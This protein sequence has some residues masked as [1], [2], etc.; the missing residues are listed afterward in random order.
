MNASFIRK[1]W[2]KWLI[3][4]AIGLGVLVLFFLVKSKTAPPK[5]PITERPRAVRVIAVPRV[6]VVP[7]AVGYG[8]VQPGMTWSAVAEVAGKIVKIHPELKK[9]ALIPKG[10]LLFKIDPE[11]Y[12]MS[13]GRSRADLENLIA[14]LKELQQREKDLRRQLN[15]EKR[16]LALA[17]KQLARKRKLYR[18]KVLS[19]SEVEKEAQNVLAQQNK[20]QSYQSSLN[21]IPAQKR[22]LQAKIAAGRIKLS[23]SGLDVAKTE[24]RAPFD[25]RISQVNVEKAQFVASGKVL[26]MADNIGYAEILAQI[27]FS[28]MDVLR[29]GIA[30]RMTP[31]AKKVDMNLIRKVLG[32]KAVVRLTMAGRTFSWRARFSRMSE[33]IDPNTGTVGVY[34]AVDRPYRK[35]RLGGRPPLIKNMFCQV[36]VRG[37]PLEGRLV[38]PRSALHGDLVYLVGP[39]NRL[40]RRRV[41]ISFLQGDLAVIRRGLKKG[42]ILVVSDLI[43]AIEGM[44]LE[45]VV[46]KPALTAL[47]AEASGQGA[48]P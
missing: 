21:Q 5:S 10:A 17:G 27:P 44:L 29:R 38:I 47:R 41:E 4:P 1:N 48:L 12:K 30:G 2:K 19:R 45:P 28:A 33:T 8:K 15:V 39:G 22:A 14:Q 42:D 36:E 3:L 23:Q 26:A 20:V 13:K 11:T 35:A 46:D 31:I 9:G 25:C 16:S 37:K 43:P 6:D 34:V 40:I 32:F 7:R 18:Q 24:I